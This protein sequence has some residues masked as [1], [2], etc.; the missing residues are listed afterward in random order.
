MPTHLLKATKPIHWAL[1]ALLYLGII[2]GSFAQT[3]PTYIDWVKNNQTYVE[4]K[5]GRQGIYRLSATMLAPHF[6]NLSSLNVAGFQMFRRGKE[7]AIFVNAGPDNVLNDNDYVEFTGLMNDAAGEEEMVQKP[8]GIRNTYRSVYDDTAYYYLTYSPALDGKR[9]ENPGLNNTSSVPFETYHWRESFR[10]FYDQYAMGAG[11]RG[12]VTFSSYFTRGEGW[13]SRAASA[14][15]GDQIV[16]GSFIHGRLSDIQNTFQGGPL[17]KL[18]LLEYGRQPVNHNVEVLVRNASNSLGTFQ[19]VGLDAFRFQAD[20]PF[21]NIQ[22]GL[23]DVWAKPLGT[24]NISLAYLRLSYPATFQM[25]SGMTDLSIRLV[26]NPGN[27]SRIRLDNLAQLPELYDVTDPYRPIRITPTTVNGVIL[28]G[29]S[30]TAD[31]RTLLIQNQP[32]MVSPNLVKVR[33]FTP[34][35]PS[36]FNYILVYHSSL[37]QPVGPVAD[38]VQA[39]IDYRNSQAGGGYQVLPLE[40]EEVYQRFGYGDRN[41]LALRNLAGFFIQR[42]VTPKAMFLLGKGIFARQRFVAGYNQMNLIPTFGVPASDNAFTVGLGGSNRAISFPVGR[43][44]ASKPQHVVAYLDKVKATESFSYNDLWKKNVLHISGGLTYLEQSSFKAIMADLTQRIQNG[45][46]GGYV[47]TFNKSSNQAVQYMDIRSL[48]NRGLSLITMFG[49]SSRSSPDVE[50]GLASDPSQ[51][52]NNAGRYPVMIVNGCNTGNIFETNLSLNEDW[53]LTPNKGAVVFWAASDEGL[54]A[55]LRR[56]ILDFYSKAFQDST[57]FGESIGVLQKAAMEKYM[58]TL[59]SEPQLDSSFM[60]Q[61]TIHGDPVIPIFSAKKADYKTSNT[62]V[63]LSTPN[64]NAS[65]ASLRLGA[66]VSNFG[67]YV[68]DSIQ[69]KVSRR[70]ANGQT[71]EFIFQRPPISTSDT[72]YFDLPQNQSFTYSGNNR[73]EV[74]IDFLNQVPEL[75]EDN[76]IGFIE[77]FIPS[78]GILPLFP[79]EYAIVNSRNVRMTIQATDLLANERRYI[80]QIDTSAL[81]QNPLAQS[82]SI[83]AG[84]VATWNYLLPFDRDSTVFYWRVRFADIQDQSDTTWYRMS[85]EYIKNASSG[86]AQSGFYQFAKST[87]QQVKKNFAQR[88]WE[89]PENSTRVDV[90]VSGG[91]KQ[92]PKEYELIINGISILRGATES[93]D[94][95]KTG[96]PR[97]LTLLLDKCSL[98]PKYWNYT[99]D[100]VGYYQAGCGRL[101]YGV[102]LFENGIANY[103]ETFSGNYNTLRIYF[104]RYIR[105]VV[106]NDDYVLV[107]PLDSINMNA[108]RTYADSVLPMIG[109]DPTSIAGL[110]NGNPFILFGKKTANPSPG[111]GQVLLPDFSS[112]VPANRQVLNFSKV[113]NSACAEGTVT[114]TLIGPASEWKDLFSRIQSDP[115]PEGERIGLEVLGVRLNGSDS[116]LLKNVVNLPTNLGWIDPVEFPYLQLRARMQ[117]SVNYSP[118]RIN[119]WMVTYEGVPE[120]L[121]NTSLIAAAN[122]KVNPVPEGDSLGFRFAFTNISEKPFRDSLTIRFIM[123]GSQIKEQKVRPLKADSTIYFEFPRFSTLGMAGTNQLLAYVNPRILPEEYYENNALN[124]PFQVVPDRTPPVLDVTFD[125]VKIRSG[126][127]VS[128][129]PLIEVLLKDENRYLIQGDT[130][131]MA[132]LLRRPCDSCAIERIPFNS[133]EV[134]VFP[135]GADNLFKVQYRPERLPNGRYFFSAEGSDVKGNRAGS[136]AYQIQF[137][138]LDEKTISRLFPYPNPFSTS[139]RWVFTVTGAIPSGLKIQIYNTTGRLVREISQEEL[140]EIH[141][142]NNIS[143]FQWDG[144]DQQGN[145]LGSGVY[146]YR[147]QLND[148][149]FRQR[150]HTADQTFY[151]EYGK[152]YIIR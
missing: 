23:L 20:V 57:L 52:F 21:D 91:S 140:G 132:L 58:S 6:E 62:E 105:E 46:L 64:P 106:Q 73:F 149:D 56:H 139:C 70:Y 30:N 27:Y 151:G 147:V 51:G 41:P 11:L 19:F 39:Y 109:I 97:F 45:Y 42:G 90:K 102:N 33:R 135:A 87:D 133:P 100:P 134:T 125:G 92:G 148:A 13:T 5:V 111:Q 18:E 77:S 17:P 72:L 10:F 124:I 137:N 126:D 24:A 145:R 128:N 37:R 141:I 119:R 104:K 101:P 1:L 55:Y 78:S 129:E 66:V 29:I 48:L 86:W 143:A 150:M 123:N 110:Q 113:L 43:L 75:Q 107:F 61:F 127:F 60:H 26:P 59:S 144:T 76:N 15:S 69:I 71:E 14:G 8:A 32:R 93:S 68:K 95:F 130:A 120:G 112:P 84:N 96:Y 94:C 40:M 22:N 88:K 146:M 114:S 81:F 83:L 80:F 49:H 36:N 44:A 54:S 89:F 9:V 47:N 28:A 2:L 116:V 50:I 99:N 53:I 16:V 25:P 118:A 108:F 117:D 3:S 63:F 82:P 98:Q 67:R 4:V 65:L 136:L 74:T 115:E 85:F 152:L 79:K 122:Y 12:N 34:I 31:S 138:V 38:P 7:Q 121:I 131:R 35:N 142:G 103:G